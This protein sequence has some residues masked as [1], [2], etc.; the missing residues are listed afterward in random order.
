MTKINR[1]RS[2][3]N[4][5]PRHAF[6]MIY[7]TNILPVVDYGGIICDNCSVYD[8]R[9]LKKAQHST[10]KIILGCLNTTSS[11]D[12]LADLNLTS[13]HLRRAGVSKLRPA[14]QI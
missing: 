7:E 8:N 9:M 11:N 10:T 14:G 5:V 2:F 3:V 13:L 6:L 1:P 12:V 4:F